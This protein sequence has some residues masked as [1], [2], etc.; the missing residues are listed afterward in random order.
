MNGNEL[1]KLIRNSSCRVIGAEDANNDSQRTVLAALVQGYSNSD[2]TILC[3]P[4][5]ARKTTR[6]PDLVL[7]DLIAGLHVIEVKGITL[8]QIEA[9]EPGGQFCIRYEGGVIG[10]NP[11]A[12]VRNSMFDIRD[13]VQRAY[14][15]ELTLP[16]R[17]WV[18]L[19]RI[20]R[21]E[22]LSHWGADALCPG[23]LLFADDIQGLSQRLLKT[24]QIALRNR[25][26]ESWPKDQIACVWRA[27][28]DS[29]VLYPRTEEREPRRVNDGT[30]GE[31]FDET[32]ETYKSLSDEQQRLSAQS[33]E[34]GPQLVRGVA[35]CGKTIVLANNLARRIHRSLSRQKELFE[36]DRPP[37]FAAVCFNR[38]LAPFIW[39]KLDIAYMQRSGD[40]LPENIVDVANFNRLM[41][42][43]AERGLW[44]YQNVEEN[45]AESQTAA[46]AKQYLADLKYVKEHDP[47]TFQRC[48]F[49]AIYVDEAQD[50]LEEE[51]QLLKELCHLENPDKEP[52]LFIFYDDAQ[53]LYARERPNWRQSFELKVKGRSHVMAECYRNTRQ[54]VEPAFNV[55]Y[56]TFT[57]DQANI[58]TKAF[59]D[60]ETLKKKKLLKKEGKIWRVHFSKR[61]G[62][63]PTVTIAENRKDQ[64]K[65][66]VEQIRWLTEEQQVRP[67]DILILVYYNNLVDEVVSA[68]KSAQFREVQGIHIATQAKNEL[69]FQ[70]G[71]VSVSTVA[72]A[73]GYDAYCVLIPSVNEF[74]TDVIGRVSFYVACT[75]AIEYVSV[76]ATSP[77]RLAGEMKKAIAA[78]DPSSEAN[79][80]AKT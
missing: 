12:Q 53:N 27:F 43:L 33:W 26:I 80:H 31:L 2:A 22:W 17:Y 42:L 61:E 76:F 73:K 21:K 60:I 3:E 18:V 7:V 57:N 68:I 71:C 39:K 5:L 63:T 52:N 72:S 37:R 79:R 4:S 20:T 15:S 35:G 47:T 11:F 55:L 25:C 41:W 54:I 74:P 58:P 46:R 77:Y 67:E 10:K 45:S 28:G 65:K 66:M 23:E 64:W 62:L 30:L 49:D 19:A 1:N 36:P 51:F 75:R 48:A 16:S 14:L 24:G 56:G 78:L 8:D 9:L 34:N 32:A 70:P 13:A 38:T 40:P 50:F 59:G 29:S 6:P 69:L 44:R